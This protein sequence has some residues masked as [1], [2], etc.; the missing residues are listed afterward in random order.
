MMINFLKKYQ[1]KIPIRTES[2][3]FNSD[4]RIIQ[5]FANNNTSKFKNTLLHEHNPSLD[6]LISMILVYTQP[7]LSRHADI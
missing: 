3:M 6:N 1:L 4:I 2:F 5:F 7:H